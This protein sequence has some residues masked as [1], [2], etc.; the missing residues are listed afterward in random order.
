MGLRHLPDLIVA[1]LACLGAF[2]LWR[3]TGRRSVRMAAL[4]GIVLVFVSLLIG[5][6]ALGRTLPAHLWTALRAS[7]IIA[8]GALLYGALVVAGFR[9]AA[10]FI[11]E[12]R[13]TLHR[14]A[15]A[16]LAA[17]AVVLGAAYIQREKLVYR[18]VDVRVPGLPKDLEG[19]RIVQVSDLHL[20]PLVSER[21]VAR[22]VDMANESRAHLAVMTGDLISVA[23][24]P[25]DACLRQV[26]RLR[27]EGG[28]FACMGNHEEY[29]LA[30][31]HCALEGAKLGIRFLRGE[32]VRL[33]F[34]SSKL[35]LAGVDYQS[36]MRKY[37]VGA[38]RLIEPGMPNILLSHN[39]D[40]FPVAAAQGFDL[41]LAGHTHGGQINFEILHRNLNIVQLMTP[42]VYGLYEQGGKSIYVTRGVGTIGVPIR[43]GAPPEVA[44][45]RLCGISS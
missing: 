18:E 5:F 40:V 12:R 34:G 21:L 25:L 11:P 6:P 9:K 28:I 20:S 26:A 35:N 19:L 4:A 17:P 10:H 32:A 29:A 1:V 39:P 2:L 23:G 31:D 24:D 14:V 8:A 7:G 38:E 16:A 41:T 27:A 43:L 3:G 15:Y 33:P 44:L 13:E 36:R 22:A 37:L 42:Y 30:T 45:I